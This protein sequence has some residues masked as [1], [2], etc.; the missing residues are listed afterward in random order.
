MQRSESEIAPMCRKVERYATDDSLFSV[1]D[2]NS[3]RVN[4]NRK[5]GESGKVWRKV[6]VK[7]AAVSQ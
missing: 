5:G 1:V 4:I 2:S 7:W 3:G 6:A